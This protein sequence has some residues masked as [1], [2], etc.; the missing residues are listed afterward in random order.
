MTTNFTPSKVGLALHARLF[1]LLFALFSLHTT[2]MAQYQFHLG[3]NSPA[4]GPTGLPIP[5]ASYIAPGHD[6]SP[7]PSLVRL[8]P[9]SY[10]SESSFLPWLKE[11][12]DLRE[13]LDFNVIGME[14]DELGFTHYQLQETHLNVPIDGAIYMVHAKDGFLTSFNGKAVSIS[15]TSARPA[16]S[17]HDARTDALAFVGADTYAWED[18][19]LE[20][21]LKENLDDENATYFPVGELVWRIIDNTPYL[22]YKFDIYSL[23]PVNKQQRVIVNAHTGAILKTLPLESNCDFAAANLV[24]YPAASIFTDK[25]KSDEWRLKDDCQG[26]K[27]RIRDWNSNTTNSNPQEIDNTTNT[28]TTNNERFG[29][30]VLWTVKNAYQYYLAVHNRD[31]YNNNGGNTEGYINAVFDSGNGTTTNNASMSF[32]GGTLKVG[33]G[34][35]LNNCYAT[36]DILGHEFTHAVT[37]N[38]AK[39]EYEGESGALNESFSDIFGEVIEKWQFGSNDW[40]M[41][42]DR[43][44][45]EIRDMSNP[46]RFNDPDTYVGLNWVSTGGSCGSSN[47]NCG[48]HTNSGVQNYWFYLLSEGGTGTNDF[49]HNYDVAGIGIEKARMIAY[50]TLVHY[51]GPNSNYNDARDFSIQAAFDLYGVCSDEVKAVT[52]AWFA[53]GIGKPYLELIVSTYSDYNGSAISCPGACDGA[54]FAFVRGTFVQT[55]DTILTGL[56]AGQH[57]IIATDNYGCQESIT[58]QLDEPEP[59][60]VS[61]APKNFYNGGVNISCYG[62]DDGGAIANVTGGTP[63]YK[64]LWS[65]GDTTESIINL[66]SGVYWVTVTDANGCAS[67]LQF[68]TLIQPS[69]LTAFALPVS[70]Y[71][72]YN[73]SCKGGQNG[74]AEAFPIGGVPPYHYQWDDFFQNTFKKADSLRAKTYTC[75]IRDANWCI[76]EVGVSLTEPTALTATASALTD[77]NGYNVPCHGGEIAKAEVV[78]G[79]GVMPYQYQWDDPN[80]STT[81]VVTNLTAGTYNVVVTDDN[82]CSKDANI[83]LTEP[84]SLS[85]EVFGSKTVYYGYPD[86]ACATLSTANPVG[87]V[88]PYTIEWSTG[89]T[90]DS[91]AVCPDVT[92]TYYVTITD[93]NGCTYT[94]SVKV[95]VIDVRCGKNLKNVMICRTVSKGNQQTEQTISLCVGKKSV[96]KF[97]NIFGALL[98]DCD[99]DRNCSI[100][101]NSR[102]QMQQALQENDHFMEAFPNPFID[103]ITLRYLPEADYDLT[104]QMFD[105]TG[106]VV[107]QVFE[108]KVMANTLYTIDYRTGALT[109]G[110]YI[111]RLETSTGVVITEKMIHGR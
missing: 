48:V 2:A 8:A 46:G 101:D 64:Y 98:G 41:G 83:T 73:V 24:Y 9:A 65:T 62:G 4:T 25:Y 80:Q 44:S 67:P 22:A 103:Q 66:T 21:E 85:I 49:G 37:G 82:A 109:P 39:L 47:D 84:D 53:V 88:P 78:A 79:G 6:N 32:S 55:T 94:D 28:W 7:Y 45:G 43:A 86:S 51:L 110:M 35:G 72:G 87:G 70:D 74:S 5:E 95:C 12:I 99:A 50:R 60:V 38:T 3:S 31:S 10:V 104:V 33:L 96:P 106:K 97:L 20:Q 93:L 102:V 100:S 42:A 90:T 81:E 18:S 17:A 54:I 52:D 58:L 29:A 1:I 57:Q 91:I 26:A 23:S 76:V 34:S 30:T 92:T 16:L 15:E 61:A 89:E 59:L 71:N 108:G 36:Q 105:I 77:F 56:C 68:V 69:A 107:D 40:L 63:P 19:T 11:A 111:L 75:E 14:T 13:G 27:F